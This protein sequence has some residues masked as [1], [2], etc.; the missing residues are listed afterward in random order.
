MASTTTV[1]AMDEA[2]KSTA[3]YLNSNRPQ[4]LLVLAWNRF[5]KLNA[6]KVQIA[7]INSTGSTLIVC[8]SDNEEEVFLP[9]PEPITDASKLVPAFQ[10]LFNKY[11]YACRP[12]LIV[13][14]IL[15]LIWSF[16]L[17]AVAS[18]V[19]AVK[20]PWLLS[21]RPY[22]LAVIRPDIAVWALVVLIVSHTIEG[23]YV[24][25]LCSRANLPQ[26]AVN[27]WVSMTFIFGYPY[28]SKAMQ[29]G[30]LGDRVRR[31][32]RQ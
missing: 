1:T 13:G 22:A 9:F 27:S 23:I 32:K 2:C 4:N 29:L 14:S 25:H 31:Q 7:E 30:A 15:V 18:E 12:P 16:L 5:G 17:F 26:H 24:V 28:T 8:S 19:D 10:K 11:S 3:D 21:L 20:Y 6:V